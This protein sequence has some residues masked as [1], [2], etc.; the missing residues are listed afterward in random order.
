MIKGAQGAQFAQKCTK[1]HRSTARMPASI[2]LEMPIKHRIHSA[3]R[4][5]QTRYGDCVVCTVHTGKHFELLPT[6]WYTS[7]NLKVTMCE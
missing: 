4:V 7:V 6:E 3:H 2:N 1:V 5:P